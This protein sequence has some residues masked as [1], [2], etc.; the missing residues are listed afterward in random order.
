MDLVLLAI[1]VLV[2]Y[3]ITAIPGLILFFCLRH[4]EKPIEM[5][6]A[7]LFGIT[8]ALLLSPAFIVAGHNPFLP[9]FAFSLVIK[10]KFTP[11]PLLWKFAVAV[12]GFFGL[13]MFQREKSRATPVRVATP[14]A[15]HKCANAD[16]LVCGVILAG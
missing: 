11:A 10:N 7:L 1:F 4:Q 6:R 15:A 2:P 13:L 9:P 14:T 5:R 12:A 16:Y 3:A 8:G